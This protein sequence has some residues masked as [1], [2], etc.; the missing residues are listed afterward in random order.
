MDEAE[1]SADPRV[2]R[3]LFERAAKLFPTAAA[4]WLAYLRW[5]QRHGD[6][7]AI[8]AI[9]GCCLVDAVEPELW[10]FYVRYLIESKLVPAEAAHVAAKQ[11]AQAAATAAVA[12]G[13]T[14]AALEAKA[15][16]DR[17]LADGLRAE[18]A[19]R[20]TVTAALDVSLKTVGDCY[21]AGG[22][23]D[24][25]VQQALAGPEGTPYEASQKREAVRKAY[26]RSVA[27]PHAEAEAHWAAYSTWE[28]EHAPATLANAILTRFTPPAATAIAVAKKLAPLWK[29]ID[30]FALP[31][32][33]PVTALA[34]MTGH[35]DGWASARPSAGA[36]GGAAA[37]AAEAASIALTLMQGPSRPLVPES[38]SSGGAGSG[39]GV[40]ADHN[41]DHDDGNG[42]G[43]STAAA[44]R[45]QA[46]QAA[47]W[48]RLR[49]FQATNPALVE[50]PISNRA[51]RLLYKQSLAALP[52]APELWADYAAWEDSVQRHAGGAGVAGDPLLSPD[53][54]S[55]V[56][57]AVFMRGTA[58]MPTCLLLVTAAADAL[59]LRNNAPAGRK[60]FDGAI[61]AL[62]AVADM[63]A[64]A[65]ATASA[66]GAAA[67]ATPAPFSLGE[68]LLRLDS[69][70]PGVAVSAATFPS[71]AEA[72][73]AAHA[74]PHAFAL[75]MRYARRTGGLDAGRAI[76]AA[77]RKSRYLAPPI[78]LAAALQELYANRSLPVARNVL[79]AG[80]KRFPRD[81]GF[82]LS[83]LDLLV[84]VDEET[85][86]RAAFDAA[87]ADLPPADARP[88][89]DRYVSYELRLAAGGGSLAAV[90]RVEARRKAAL[91]HL[92]APTHSNAL[93]QVLHRAFEF[94]G[95]PLTRYDCAVLAAAPV[96]PLTAV[97]AAAAGAGATGDA[98]PS[99]LAPCAALSAQPHE[100]AAAAC[101]GGLLPSK[102][103]SAQPS[104][105][106]AGGAAAAAAAAAATGAA[107]T[108]S[109][110]AASAAS[111]S[112]AALNS[113]SSL[114]DGL[115]P[116]APS[117]VS[118]PLSHIPVAAA[119]LAGHASAAASAAVQAGATAAA[120][121]EA[122]ARGPPPPEVLPAFVPLVTM[123]PRVGDLLRR[124]PH[125][126]AV[127]DY[128]PAIRT[129][130][131][132]VDALMQTIAPAAAQAAAAAA[133]AG[134]TPAPSSGHGH[135]HSAATLAAPQPGQ[136]RMG[137]HAFGM[138]APAP[139]SAA[140]QPPLLG[141]PPLADAEAAS[142]AAAAK[143]PRLG[144]GS[145]P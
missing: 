115:F 49:A 76:F 18:Q 114:R 68:A 90:M 3:P 126:P 112:A 22:L 59:E 120:V 16:A 103:P 118:S 107:L 1:A 29:D 60:L 43:I 37:S 21:H 44:A 31:T 122:A 116:Q 132:A 55:A 73:A 95:P 83:S 74:V 92:F 50:L 30:R 45:R 94:G 53:E 32:P 11:R 56:A 67:V 33:P 57:A 25:L 54:A 85:N 144:Y 63:H 10:S 98:A 12:A 117:L 104:S 34:Q 105:G 142:A 145:E 7:A 121:A 127:A 109:S 39:L 139:A 136:K 106:A 87:L 62:T 72:A 86:V 84:L 96:A 51:L 23:W 101:S 19:A 15:A 82:V 24:L 131:D 143:R 52:Y 14:A 141:A 134:Q 140:A 28:R 93:T 124:L 26:Q 137:K 89:W 79:E 65:A 138:P 8:E 99:V 40:D 128:P 2:A 119:L 64:A 80:R 129:A 102:A 46:A 70:P 47:A 5:E 108:G 42:G 125:L 75:A 66:A 13:A 77:A 130:A 6:Q 135:G 123:A 4:V 97:S 38:S 36:G 110:A 20:E 9:L 35:P 100:L 27:V 71:A 41:A 81:V 91:P 58:L 61:A 17:E 48:A 111:T 88:V 69:L 113:W 133:V 78:Y